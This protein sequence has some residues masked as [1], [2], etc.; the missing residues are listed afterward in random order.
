MGYQIL[1]PESRFRADDRQPAKLPQRPTVTSVS[2]QYAQNKDV[3][4]C[5]GLRCGPQQTLLDGRHKLRATHPH[6]V[7][8]VN[9]SDRNSQKIE[10]R[11]LIADRLTQQDADGPDGSERCC[12][13]VISWGVHLAQRQRGYAR[14]RLWQN[15][16]A[17]DEESGRQRKGGDLLQR[18]DHIAAGR[19]FG[20]W[21]D[22]KDRAVSR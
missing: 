18:V 7:V 10:V 5:K 12:D 6:S 15:R 4:I 1:L 3:P 19:A 16:R 14:V 11:V 22:L 9:V 8:G 13:G 17:W 2:R 21:R 20:R